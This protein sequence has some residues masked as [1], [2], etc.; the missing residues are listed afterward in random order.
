[1]RSD[2]LFFFRTNLSGLAAGRL[3]GALTLLDL[4]KNL[5]CT[6]EAEMRDKTLRRFLRR[7]TSGASGLPEREGGELVL[8]KPFAETKT[9][10]CFLLRP[11]EM[12]GESPG[13]GRIG[14]SGLSSLD[15]GVGRP[16][17]D[18]RFCVTHEG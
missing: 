1:M 3:S 6:G 15:N 13:S 5:L 9:A 14:V 2:R 12:L 18:G 11:L 8:N 4:E 7:G 10:L 17:P 16:P